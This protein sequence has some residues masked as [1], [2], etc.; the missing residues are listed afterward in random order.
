MGLTDIAGVLSRRLIVG[1]FTPA[2]FTTLALSLLVAEGTLPELYRDAAGGTKILI[3]G[4]FALLAGLLLSGLQ[5]PLLRLAEGYWL[6]NAPEG[7]RRKRLSDRLVERH[8]KVFEELHAAKQA[9][10]VS[11]ARTRAALALDRLYPPE[12]HLLL[13]TKLGN[14]IRA[15]ESHPTQRYGLDGIAAWPR[16]SLLLDDGERAALDEAMT[17]FAFFF[18]A[19]VCVNAAA[20]V[21]IVDRLWHA[22]GGVPGTA[23]IVL[24]VVAATAALS[25]LMYRGLFDAATGWGEPVRAAF[26]LHRFDLYDRLGIR[27]P[28]T[29]AE[30]REH[31]ARAVNRLLLYAEPIP[32]EW[33]ARPATEGLPVEEY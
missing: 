17:N 8:E 10:A 21:L 1:C 3:L 13:P 2:F 33:R 30:E 16:I 4:G 7:R 24:A 6:F 32:D 15:F 23:A 19:L 27:R 5:Y 12:R 14:A 28:A 20:L 26:D 11:P 22:P 25:W 31:A 9:T 29:D 18:N